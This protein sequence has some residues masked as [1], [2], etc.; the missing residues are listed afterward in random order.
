MVW[1]ACAVGLMLASCNA[2]AREAYEVITPSGQPEAVFNTPP[3]RIHNLIAN[4]CLKRG[5]HVVTNEAWTVTCQ[6]SIVD[7]AAV[8]LSPR[9]ASLAGMVRFTII[10]LGDNAR[11]QASDW[12]DATNAFGGT[13][14]LKGIAGGYAQDLLISEG[15]KYPSG[16]TFEGLDLGFTGHFSGYRFHVKSVAAGSS[17]AQG[18]LRDGDVI[19]KV[20]GHSFDDLWWFRHKVNEAQVGSTITFD[21]MRG[22]ERL[23]IPVVAKAAALEG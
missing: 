19:R 13:K 17:S 11:V 20:N 5:W 8:L 16:T 22:K 2:Q 18:G 15:G 14:V 12:V 4:G 9:G 6:H 1:K 3:D 21:V 23:K 10:D 7:N